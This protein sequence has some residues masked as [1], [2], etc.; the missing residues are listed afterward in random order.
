MYAARAYRLNYSPS[1][2]CKT[3]ATDLALCKF[4]RQLCIAALSPQHQLAYFTHALLFNTA[5]HATD[6]LVIVAHALRRMFLRQQQ[7]PS[8]ACSTLPAGRRL[9]CSSQRLATRCGHHGAIG[10]RRSME[11]A[12]VSQEGI[13]VPEAGVSSAAFYCIFDGHGGDACAVHA[14][15]H[16]SAVLCRQ[17][18]LRRS[19]RAALCA[20]FQEIDAAFIVS[21][22]GRGRTGAT[23]I[24]VAFDG[25]SK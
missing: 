22:E 11:D 6:D 23:A 18:S 24:S 25:V 10:M 9:S 5:Q 21:N 17:L 16:Y 4:T 3:Q 1:N 13:S 15:A 20:T 14:A 8:D 2:S 12:A 7:Q 19:W